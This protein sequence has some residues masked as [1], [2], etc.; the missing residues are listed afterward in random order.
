MKTKPTFGSFNQG[1]KP[2]IACFRDPKLKTDL[3]VDFD[4][5][6]DAMKV[7][8][9]KYVAPVWGA[10]AT[11]KKSRGFLPGCW[12]IV[13]IENADEAEALGYHELTPDGLPISKVFVKTTIDDGEKV[14]VTASHELVEMLVDPAINL[15]TTGPNDLVY[16]YESADPVEAL[17]FDVHGIPMSDFVYPAY[18]ED[19][20]KPN[21]V[22]FDEMNTVH[23][24][25]EILHGGYQII[26]KNGKWQQIY[27][28]HH[29]EELFSKEN[30]A[31]HRSEQRKVERRCWRDSKVTLHAAAS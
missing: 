2:T 7:Y 13:F 6:I 15:L 17:S 4:K 18:F 11:V 23:K 19:F 14:S 1:L 24:P 5:L 26:L 28:S 29:K 12:A 10:P 21:S 3:G 25:F 31:L 9:D 8:V 27:G 30:R 20:H 22:R 16:A